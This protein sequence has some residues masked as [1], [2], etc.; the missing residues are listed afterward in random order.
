MRIAMQGRVYEI[1]ELKDGEYILKRSDATDEPLVRIKF[2]AEAS[3]FLSSA[4]TGIAK[5]MIEAGLSHV[6]ELVENELI[7]HD[8][9]SDE[10]ITQTLH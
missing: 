6:E 7:K 2:S 10:V 5:T 4:R 9:E 1:V 3:D 8:V